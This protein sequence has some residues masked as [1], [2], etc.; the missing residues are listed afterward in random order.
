MDKD[1]VTVT[2][3]DKTVTVSKEYTIFNAA[4]EAGV[5]IPTLCHLDLHDLKMVNRTASCRVC[6]VEVEGSPKLSPACATPVNDG[7]KVKTDTMKAITARRMSVELLL[8]NHPTDCL[9]CQK[10]PTV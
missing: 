2:I 3:N 1:K 10:E 7:M 8:S 9:I 4:V 5:K 6:M